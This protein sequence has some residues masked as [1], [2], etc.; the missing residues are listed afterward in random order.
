[1][2][3]F[4]GFLKYLTYLCIAGWMFFLGIMVGRG[5]APVT[6]D[7]QKF[8][9]RLEIIANEFGE[10]K[11]TSKRMDLKFY[12][13]LDS[14]VQEEPLLSKNKPLEIMPT[15]EIPEEQLP[16][17]EMIENQTLVTP[18]IIPSKTSRK[19]ITFK[20]RVEKR[21]IEKGTI[22]NGIIEKGTINIPKTQ[23]GKYTIQVAAYNEFKEAISLMARLDEKGFTSYR[24]KGEKN[25]VVLYRVR[26]GSFS[27]WDEAE[28]MKE[29][30]KSA[31]IN[32][33]IIRKDD[34]EDIKG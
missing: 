21:T 33:M 25:G 10:K 17:K 26:I 24:V 28:K 1:M 20:K 32:A 27:T 19:R 34:D 31:K 13:A 4:R 2:A 8:Q 29:K 6:F 18:D 3:S 12:D 22:G 30:L 9:K 23:Q 14:P 11:D 5:N 7:T 15:R 16:E